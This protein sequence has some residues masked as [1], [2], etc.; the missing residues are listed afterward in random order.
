MLNYNFDDMKHFQAVKVQDGYVVCLPLGDR[1]DGSHHY[2]YDGEHISNTYNHNIIFVKDYTK[3]Q[4]YLCSE[5]IEYYLLD[6]YKKIT[7]EEYNDIKKR[8]NDFTDSVDNMYL[9]DHWTV[10]QS[11]KP[12]F[13]LS[14]EV[15]PVE[16]KLVGTCTTTNDE[17]IMPSIG[18]GECEST[19]YHFLFSKFV[20]TQMENFYPKLERTRNNSVI[21]SLWGNNEL[22][23]KQYAICILS[24]PTLDDAKNFKSGI[25][26]ILNN[27]FNMLPTQ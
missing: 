14:Q 17:Y 3:V 2:R 9:P 21:D 25:E 11:Y 27:H 16:I 5:E 19:V 20:I 7:V 15:V 24:F 22:L 10:L 18:Y 12:I 8:Y 26:E 13:K 1:R 4:S 23:R 6:D